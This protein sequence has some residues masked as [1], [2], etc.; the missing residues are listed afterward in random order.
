MDE[1]GPIP[2]R[3]LIP[4][5][6]NPRLV[7][8]R[9]RSERDTWRPPICDSAGDADDDN[10]D[11][12]ALR[13]GST[14][15]HGPCHEQQHRSESSDDES[16]SE[17]LTYHPPSVFL[18]EEESEYYLSG[19]QSDWPSAVLLAGTSDQKNMPVPNEP[20]RL[21]FMKSNNTISDKDSSLFLLPIPFLQPILL[22]P[23]HAPRTRSRLVL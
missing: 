3:R 22:R 5:R 9:P 1:L 7:P 21:L 17:P 15:V 4:D 19:V 20:G 8:N 10:Q 6:P 16:D 2:K 12:P 13:K 23:V 11:G 18:T 14:D